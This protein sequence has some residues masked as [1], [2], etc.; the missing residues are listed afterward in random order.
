[1]YTI[2]PNS[3]RAA[4]DGIYRRSVLY[5]ES[6]VWGGC[7]QVRY[8]RVLKVIMQ[9]CFSSDF[10]VDVRQ[11]SAHCICDGDIFK[12]RLIIG[13]PWTGLTIA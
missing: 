1:M 9:I 4:W 7:A 11:S 10:C 8:D 5:A 6:A 12:D 13:K 3:T 2:Y